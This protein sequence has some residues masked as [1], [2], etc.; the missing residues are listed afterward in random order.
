[1]IIS[2]TVVSVNQIKNG[3]RNEL[4]SKLGLKFGQKVLQLSMLLMGVANIQ[5]LQGSWEGTGF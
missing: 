4:N 3:F 5:V 2:I 1:M